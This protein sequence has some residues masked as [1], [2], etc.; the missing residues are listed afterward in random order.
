MKREIIVEVRNRGRAI[1]VERVEEYIGAN[2][3]LFWNVFV[4]GIK[5]QT[6][7]K[8][9]DMFRWLGNALEDGS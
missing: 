2:Y 6:N 7:L 5:T 3:V 9:E 4:D 1:R 8:A